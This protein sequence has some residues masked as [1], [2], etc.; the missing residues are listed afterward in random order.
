MDAIDWIPV[1]TWKELD[2]QWI[3]C[4]AGINQKALVKKIEK[5][6]LECRIHVLGW[7]KNIEDVLNWCDVLI[8]LT[9]MDAFPNVTLEAMMK[10][11][12]IITN[13]DSCGTKEQVFSDLNGI[14]INDRKSF[15]EALH[16]YAY[17]RNVKQ[18]HGKAGKRVV[19][20]R[21]TVSIQKK[22]MHKALASVL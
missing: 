6:N 15:I 12:P 20:E 22:K 8:H 10:E 21:F 18:V 11:K 14:V 4:G 9:K 17:E 16:K 13:F 3:I 19:K 1:N 2:I 5:Y 7:I